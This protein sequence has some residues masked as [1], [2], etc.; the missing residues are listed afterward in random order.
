MSQETIKYSATA[1]ETGTEVIGTQ[2]ESQPSTATEQ[3]AQC[4]RPLT[5]DDIKSFWIQKDPAL[6]GL[7]AAAEHLESQLGQCAEGNE[8]KRVRLCEKIQIL[9]DQINAREQGILNGSIQGGTAP[10]F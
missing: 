2:R 10:S 7:N 9:K 8:R 6:C 3:D 4:R 5:E 1:Q